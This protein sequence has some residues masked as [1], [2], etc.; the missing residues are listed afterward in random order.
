MLQPL[1]RRWNRLSQSRTSSFITRD[2]VGRHPMTRMCIVVVGSGRKPQ[3][4]LH[5]HLQD[6]ASLLA[7][8]D[9]LHSSS[10]RLMLHLN[11]SSQVL[12]VL[13]LNGTRVK[14]VGVALQFTGVPLKNLYLACHSAAP[15]SLAQTCLNLLTGVYTTSVR[16][17]QLVCE[18]ECRTV[19]LG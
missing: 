14:E 4:R 2:V 10:P 9:G 8:Y 3:G 15:A 5:C 18:P 12:E 13:K 16:A 7:D 11:V 6:I 1:P 19:F 17:L